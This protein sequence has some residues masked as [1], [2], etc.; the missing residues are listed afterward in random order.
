[1]VSSLL[2]ATDFSEHSKK[3]VDYAF[4]LKQQFDC[5][6][7]ML[8]VVELTNA[9]RFGVRQGHFKDAI[10]RMKRW[11]EDQLENLTP[12]Q[13][14]SDSSVHWLIEE[15]TPSDHIAACA[16]THDVDMIVLG[17][18]GYGPVH[19][20]FVGTTTDKVLLNMSRPVMTVKI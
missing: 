11:A 17:A 12:H 1:M 13:F 14:V 3:V 7:Y 9:I 4:E 16:E 2:V 6:I 8:Y 19:Q 18:H 5:E 10:P 15:G 20:H